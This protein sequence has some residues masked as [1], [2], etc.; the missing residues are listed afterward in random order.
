MSPTRQLHD[1]GQSL[2]LDNITRGLYQ[3]DSKPLHRRFLGH[4]PSFESVDLRFGDQEFEL[5]RRC[6]PPE[7]EAGQVG[8]SA[9]LRTCESPRLPTPASTTK[10]S[11]PTC[12]AKG[13]SRSSHPGRICSTASSRGTPRSKLPVEIH[14][15]IQLPPRTRSH[16][17]SHGLVPLRSRPAWRALEEHCA[18][19]R[20][21]HLLEE[22][23]GEEAPCERLW[24]D[25]MSRDGELFAREGAMEAAW[26]VV[27]PV[28]KTLRRGLYSRHSWGPKD[29]DTFIASNGDWQSTS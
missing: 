23:P 22:Q 12:S 8:R 6:H 19:V 26:A 17:P 18:K 2:W 7:A 13:P 20:N 25:A 10:N 27:D 1:L 5:L 9:L 21:L 16:S 28:L 4:W 11:R 29:A 3:R 15:T 14:M 24:G